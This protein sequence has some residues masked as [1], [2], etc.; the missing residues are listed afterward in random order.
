[1]ENPGLLRFNECCKEVLILDSPM[2][3]RYAAQLKF[4]LYI[5]ILVSQFLLI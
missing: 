5:S 3:M 1:M 2:F 4:S